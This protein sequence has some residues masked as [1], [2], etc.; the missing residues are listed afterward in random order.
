MKKWFASFSERSLPQ[1]AEFMCTWGTAVLGVLL[2][3]QILVLP[4]QLLL[5]ALLVGVLVIAGTGW[6]KKGLRVL[7]RV[8]GLLL[9]AGVLVSGCRG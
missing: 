6:G 7:G 9:P 5:L 1:Q 3:F 8:L 2:L 4:V